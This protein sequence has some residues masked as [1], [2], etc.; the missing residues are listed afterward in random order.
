MEDLWEKRLLLW[1]FLD[2]SLRQAVPL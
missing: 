2:W 1:I